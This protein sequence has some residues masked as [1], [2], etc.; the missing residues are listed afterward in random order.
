MK[1]LKYI[2]AMCL[3]IGLSAGAAAQ[4]NPFAA[5][6]PTNP[7]AT[8]QADRYVGSFGSDAVKLQLV[9]EGALYKGELY[10]IA[11]QKTYP[12]TA[13]LVGDRL[14]GMFNAVGASFPFTFKLNDNGG[15]GV[16]TTEGFEGTLVAQT[17]DQTNAQGDAQAGTKTGTGNGA[18]QTLT[19]T[20]KSA[21]GSEAEVLFSRALVLARSLPAH[22]Q[23]TAFAALI[24]ARVDA[25]DMADAEKLISIM[26]FAD[27]TSQ[28]AVSHLARGYA[29]RGDIATALAKA[30]SIAGQPI[31]ANFAYGYVA[32]A[33]AKKGDSQNALLLVNKIG[34]PKDKMHIYAPVATAQHEAGDQSGANATLEVGLKI[35]RKIR[36]KEDRSSGLL[37]VSSAYAR[38]SEPAQGIAVAQ[39]IPIALYRILAL[40][41]VA[42]EQVKADD[43]SGAK[44]TIVLA[45]KR[46]NKVDA[47]LKDAAISSV[48]VAKASTGDMA[49]AQLALAGI[50]FEGTRSSGNYQIA[51]AQLERNNFEG[52]R[53]TAVNIGSIYDG[54]FAVAWAKARAR[55]GDFAKATETAQSIGSPRLQ[56]EAYAEIAAEMRKQDTQE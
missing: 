6:K 9:R 13:S 2:A 20:D 45:E 43:M 47:L 50:A 23:A 28:L 16:F 29:A 53:T 48:A 18:T 41:I 26:P 1:F 21:T 34:A 24:S 37:S 14:E 44:A 15:D 35:A 17:N 31:M 36:K 39:D 4:E 27:I 38:I 32:G 25:G 42:R 7:F 51:V 22:E 33:M 55:A 12:L 40:T 56:S 11:T 3:V 52:A 8:A 46:L 49:G 30:D 54:Q 10:Y 5:K 19:T